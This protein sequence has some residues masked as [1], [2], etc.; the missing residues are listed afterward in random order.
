[1]RQLAVLTAD[2]ESKLRQSNSDLLSQF[3]N[4]PH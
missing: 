4:V 3:L 2:V 1:M